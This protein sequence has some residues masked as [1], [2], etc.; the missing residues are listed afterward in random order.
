MENLYRQ[1]RLAL[2]SIRIGCC[3]WGSNWGNRLRFRKEERKEERKEAAEGE[4][5]E[6]LHR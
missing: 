3:W 6:T 1:Q 5:E 2:W 4:V